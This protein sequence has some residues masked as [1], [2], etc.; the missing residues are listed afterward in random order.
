M[1]ATEF[2][3]TH[4]CDADWIAAMGTTEVIALRRGQRG[5]YSGFPASVVRHDVNGMYEIRV[6]GGV[7]CVD[8]R[9]F[10]AEALA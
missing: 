4:D 6:P 3:K 8:G 5:T 1:N 10:V 9:Y 7:T 2:A